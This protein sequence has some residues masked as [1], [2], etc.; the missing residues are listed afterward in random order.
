MAAA[1]RHR[2]EIGEL[3]LDHGEPAGRRLHQ[4]GA[5]RHRTRI[6]VDADDLCAGRFQNETRVTAGAES[7]IDINAA[8]MD[9]ELL[10]GAAA[11]HGNVGGWSASDSRKAVAARR[12]SRAPSALRAA[13][14]EPS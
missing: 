13:I 11:E 6:A 5:H 10:D 14:E 4:I 2:V 1:L 12:H 9:I 7:A 8:I 3:V